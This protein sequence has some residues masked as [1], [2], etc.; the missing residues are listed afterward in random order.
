MFQSFLKI[1]KDDSLLEFGND[2]LD[3]EIEGLEP[4]SI[5]SLKNQLETLDVDRV[6]SDFIIECVS[7]KYLSHTMKIVASNRIAGAD[8]NETIKKLSMIN[9]ND[10]FIKAITIDIISFVD[11][12]IKKY[13]FLGLDSSLL[14]EFLLEKYKNYRIGKSVATDVGGVSNTFSILSLLFYKKNLEL[15]YSDNDFENALQLVDYVNYSRKLKGPSSQIQKQMSIISYLSRNWNDMAATVAIRN[16]I[17]PQ[18]TSM[19]GGST[20]DDLTITKIFSGHYNLVGDSEPRTAVAHGLISDFKMFQNLDATKQEQLC[21]YLLR[22]KDRFNNILKNNVDEMIRYLDTNIRTGRSLREL[23]S[24]KYISNLP[25]THGFT[26]K[27]SGI[28][29]DTQVVINRLREEYSRAPLDRL[30]NRMNFLAHRFIPIV[31]QFKSKCATKY[32]NQLTDEVFGKFAKSAELAFL[33]DYE[34]TTPSII[35]NNKSSMVPVMIGGDNIEFVNNEEV[36]GGATPSEN[37]VQKFFEGQQAYNKEYDELYRRL[38]TALNEAKINENIGK[39]PV[40]AGS[41]ESISIKSPETPRYLSGYYGAKNY[42]RLY[43]KALN[44]LKNNITNF[45]FERSL[46]EPM[47]IVNSMISLQDRTYEKVNKLRNDF[48]KSPKS[49]SELLMVSAEK[50][51]MSTLT[52]K[53]FIKMNDGIKRLS[54]QSRASTSTT[55]T[56]QQLENYLGKLD[57]RTQIIE[58]YYK[59]ELSMV[60]G[61]FNMIPRLNRKDV[62]MSVQ[63]SLINAKKDCLIY[64]NEVLDENI[65]KHRIQNLNKVTLTDAQIDRIEK[66]LLLFRNSQ[67]TNDCHKYVEKINKNLNPDISIGTVFSLIKWLKKLFARSNYLD[68][69]RTIYRELGIMDINWQKFSDK[70]STLI[71]V[72][73]INLERKITVNGRTYTRS[74]LNHYLAQLF[75]TFCQQLN[76]GNIDPAVP[77]RIAANKI[78]FY[79]NSGYLMMMDLLQDNEDIKSDD[80]LPR[81]GLHRLNNYAAAATDRVNYGHIRGQLTQFQVPEEFDDAYTIALGNVQ[82]HD[83][84]NNVVNTF[85]NATSPDLSFIVY[86]IEYLHSKYKTTTPAP[87]YYRH[88]QAYIMLLTTALQT[89]DVA[90]ASAIEMRN[91]INAQIVNTNEYAVSVMNTDLNKNKMEAKLINYTMDSLF[92]NVLGM[93]DDYWSIRFSGSLGLPVNINRLLRG[94]DKQDGGTIFDTLTIAHPQQG[95]VIPEATPFYVCAFNVIQFYI[96]TY[97]GTTNDPYVM[98]LKLHINQVSQLYPL[99]EVFKN[100]TLKT[101]SISDMKKCLAVFNDIWSQSSGNAS[102]KLVQSIDFLF[103]ELNASFIFTDKLQLDVLE[104]TGSMS[105]LLKESLSE[106]VE[107]LVK[108]MTDTMKDTFMDYNLSPEIQNKYFEETL[109]QAYKRIQSEPVG[110]RMTLLK[111]LLSSQNNADDILQ[112]YY[113]FMELTITPLIIWGQTYSN[114][115][116][117]FDSYQFNS[118]ANVNAVNLADINVFYHDYSDVTKTRRIDNMWNLVRL[119]VGGRYDLKYALMENPAVLSW[120][121]LLLT[122]A[123]T[124]FHQT[125][126]FV[127]PKFWIVLDENSYPTSSTLNSISNTVNNEHFVNDN[128]NSMMQI[129]P[130]ISIDDRPTVAQFFDVAFNECMNDFDHYVTAILSYPGI[131]DRVRRKVNDAVSRVKKSLNKTE[132]DRHKGFLSKITIGKTGA[133]VP[134]PPYPSKVFIPMYNEGNINTLSISNEKTAGHNIQIDHT[135]LFI[136]TKIESPISTC[137]Y[138]WIDWVLFQIAQCDKTMYCVPARFMDLF[139]TFNLNNYVHRASV[140]KRGGLIYSPEN[141]STFGNLVTQNIIARSVSD[142]NRAKLELA[143]LSQSWIAS[144]VAVCP[145]L[146]NTLTAHR[147]YMATNVSYNGNNTN[148]M[149]SELIQAI[150]SFYNELINYAPHVDFMTDTPQV[151]VVA[152]LLRFVSNNCSA[153]MKSSDFIKMNWANKYFF[154][155]GLSY[156]EHKGKSAFGWMEEYCSDKINNSVFNNSFNTTIQTLARNSWSSLIASSSD[157]NTKFKNVNRDSDELILQAINILSECDVGVIQ[158]VIDNITAKEIVNGSL[159]GGDSANKHTEISVDEL[160]DEYKKVISNIT[161]GLAS[162]EMVVDKIDW[163][164]PSPGKI[165]LWMSNTPACF[166]EFINEKMVAGKINSIHIGITPSERNELTYISEALNNLQLNY[167]ERTAK[168]FYR[169]NGIDTLLNVFQQFNHTTTNKLRQEFRKFVAN[170]FVP[171]YTAAIDTHGAVVDFRNNRPYYNMLLNSQSLLNMLNVHMT[172]IRNIFLQ[173]FLDLRAALIAFFDNTGADANIIRMIQELVYIASSAVTD[174]VELGPNPIAR[175]ADAADVG[176]REQY[177]TDFTNQLRSKTALIF[178]PLFMGDVINLYWVLPVYSRISVDAAVKRTLSIFDDAGNSHA[179]GHGSNLEAAHNN[180]LIHKREFFYLY[181]SHYKLLYSVYFRN[182]PMIKEINQILNNEIISANGIADAAITIGGGAMCAAVHT[183]A[184]A[185]TNA[186]LTVFFNTIRTITDAN[187]LTLFTVAAGRYNGAVAAGGVHADWTATPAS[188]AIVNKFIAAAG[189]IARINFRIEIDNA[190]RATTQEEFDIAITKAIVGAFNNVPAN[191]AGTINKVKDIVMTILRPLHIKITNALAFTP[192]TAGENMTNNATLAIM[193]RAAYDFVDTDIVEKY[194]LSGGAILNRKDMILATVRGIARNHKFKAEY[195]DPTINLSSLVLPLPVGGIAGPAVVPDLNDLLLFK[196]AINPDLCTL[197]NKS[198]LNNSEF[199]KLVLARNEKYIVDPIIPTN[200]ARHIVNI[201]HTR[202]HYQINPKQFAFMNTLLPAPATVP[203]A[204]TM[205]HAAIPVEW[206]II[207]QP[208][209]F[210]L[211][212]A[213][214]DAGLISRY[215]TAITRLVGNY[216]DAAIDDTAVGAIGAAGNNNYLLNGTQDARAFNTVSADAAAIANTTLPE[217]NF[218]F[219]MSGGV[220]RVPKPK[221]IHIDEFMFVYTNLNRVVLQY[222]FSPQKDIYNAT[223]TN[224]YS[225]YMAPT[226]QTAIDVTAAGNK[227]V[228]VGTTIATAN[229]LVSHRHVVVQNN[230]LQDFKSVSDFTNYSQNI[231]KNFLS[232]MLDKRTATVLDPRSK[233]NNGFDSGH[234]LSRGLLGGIVTTNFPESYINMENE[235]GIN[236]KEKLSNAYNNKEGLTLYNELFQRIEVR[237]GDTRFMFSLVLNYFHK[238]NISFNSIYNQICFPSIIYGAASLNY[239]IYNMSRSISRLTYDENA[240]NFYNTLLKFAKT[241]LDAYGGTSQETALNK[242]DNIKYQIV[243]KIGYTRQRNATYESI[244]EEFRQLAL[245]VRGDIDYQRNKML[246]VS[247]QYTTPS[248]SNDFL[249]FMVGS[250]NV[251]KDAN[252]VVNVLR[253][254]KNNI[255]QFFYSNFMNTIRHVDSITTF[256]NVI[257]LLLRQTSYYNVERN[258]DETYISTDNQDIFSI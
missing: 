196:Y 162:T 100:T 225:Q 238:Y 51:Q 49:S 55:N 77:N 111:T 131:S 233:F 160:S 150:V 145:F 89:A 73:T 27:E 205:N 200:L 169:G 138:T 14:N 127:V 19:S 182:T 117:L 241:Y 175:I 110:Q 13:E 96:K 140:E 102:A 12:E 5:S 161:T 85:R 63:N 190:I 114:I 124:N 54:L 7:N 129:W 211:A 43:K 176:Q 164:L 90:H 95:E 69:I 156:P 25:S 109:S 24:G 34:T 57:K 56:K 158:Q 174:F 248:V 22:N 108:T 234:H 38:A 130:T 214:T 246:W 52:T 75:E 148:K 16:E 224:V 84:L 180:N 6:V 217:N 202:Y 221:R 32:G 39:I 219:V 20:D 141:S 116:S 165:R 203:N 113:K 18:R 189:M 48:L 26:P 79:Q 236:M 47:S 125:R 36:V 215:Y 103:N 59:Q 8:Y 46:S 143:T 216:L 137:S 252:D 197:F 186:F 185:N 120:N 70:I 74:S 82:F 226:I 133:Y 195:I 10:T 149:L 123:L 198:G 171:N 220:T 101:I 126:R 142:T 104:S 166:G 53:D 192:A 155:V 151:S 194:T 21:N 42:N 206:N 40:V 136:A 258:N 86:A 115:F 178:N 242:A 135:S 134:P 159:R 227:Y 15:N 167:L 232:E 50:I 78:G 170:T 17:I 179:F 139:S 93:V 91:T 44:E 45:G 144:L 187:F 76:A 163:K 94:G 97:S 201:D 199:M 106:N 218:D 191:A 107:V 37:L 250:T 118:V 31:Q 244:F 210:D 253:D 132:L 64:L 88:L 61:E 62:I 209:P 152:D 99:Y 30:N 247:N 146:V 112:E 239:A 122:N 251:S 4:S 67:N 228:N 147:N 1:Q 213:V 256:V 66:A 229:G 212:V 172:N 204:G 11:E 83:A 80:A 87:Y 223:L 245:V 181:A 188:T 183:L 23:N 235:Y 81:Y 3:S 58:D 153:E 184:A 168:S 249:S 230:V 92:V 240:R 71:A 72:S 157:Y 222:I 41:F 177:V 35:T 237:N 33:T 29:N 154:N 231:V 257:F 9:I 243:P 128:I 207:Q 28:I 255:S 173:A 68:F 193:T 98:R 119:I 60:T 65:T 208:A 105:G 2:I 121:K 254:E